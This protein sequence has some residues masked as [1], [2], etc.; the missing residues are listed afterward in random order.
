MWPA[1]EI[2]ALRAARPEPLLAVDVTSS[3]GG[4]AMRWTDA[5]AWF[6]SVQKCLGLPAGMGYLVVGPRVLEAARRLAGRVANW[7]RLATMAAKMDEG[8]TAETPNVLAI[9]LLARQMA[10]WD[11]ARVERDTTAKAAF[12]YGAPLPWKPYVEDA[13]W[14]SATVACFRVDDPGRWAERAA[15]AGFLLGRGYGDL[16]STCVRVANFPAITAEDLRRLVAALA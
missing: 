5:D 3:F 7:Q 6:G 4:L 10:R 12:L 14:R 15:A 13:A 9:A 1:T 8:Q 11:L 16:K 2:A